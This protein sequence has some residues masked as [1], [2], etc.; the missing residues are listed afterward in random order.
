MKIQNLADGQSTSAQVGSPNTGIV[1]KAVTGSVVASTADIQVRLQVT[2]QN[3][4]WATFTTQ[5][6]TAGN[7]N[8]F[9]FAVGTPGSPIGQATINGGTIGD[10]YGLC[11]ALSPDMSFNDQVTVKLTTLPSGSVGTFSSCKIWYVDRKA[12]AAA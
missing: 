2:F 11:A 5:L 6:I 3:S 1:L 7:Q 8:E 4:I 10:T 12:K 9:A